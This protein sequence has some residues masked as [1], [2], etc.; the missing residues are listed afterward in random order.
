M[1]VHAVHDDVDISLVAGVD[2][3]FRPRYLLC[4]LF[5]VVCVS[6]FYC[7]ELKRLVTPIEITILQ[8]V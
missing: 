2:Q 3:L 1:I 7:E 6:V 8:A 5:E 4:W